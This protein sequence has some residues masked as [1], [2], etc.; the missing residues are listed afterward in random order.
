MKTL[1]LIFSLITCAALF[2]QAQTPGHHHHDKPSVHG[3]LIAGASKIY[4][5]HL[6]MFHSPHDYQVIFE[7][8]FSSAG[9][10]A[11]LAGLK[12]SNETVYT[13]VPESF[14]LPDMVQT[15]KPFAAQIYQGHFERG[16]LLI[17]SQVKVEITKVI[18]FKKLD[19]NGIKPLQ[20]NYIL[21]GNEKE[22]FL[23]HTISAKP[24]FDQ[25]L[26]VEAIPSLSNALK[27]DGFLSLT[28]KTISNESPLTPPLKASARIQKL[29][30][31]IQLQIDS[32]LYMETG[33]LSF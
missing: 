27:T 11:Y 15:P 2:C 4:L 14:V 3:M 1:I 9:Q 21:F 6:P 10:A 12:G 30:K 18:Y 33:D 5:S 24:D 7:A 17:A 25:I 8:Q 20:G 23:A 32:S 26:K 29:N 28:F 19:P 16:G 31:N 22:Q 13:L